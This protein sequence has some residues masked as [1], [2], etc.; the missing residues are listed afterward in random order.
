MNNHW[1]NNNLE[2]VMKQFREMSSVVSP[3]AIEAMKVVEANNSLFRLGAVNEALLKHSQ[4]NSSIAKGAIEAL[5]TAIKGL[6]YS[7]SI[8]AV[9]LLQ[10][11][12]I[13]TIS[14]QMKY[15]NSAISAFSQSSIAELNLTNI[16]NLA[17]SLKAFENLE[18]KEN[19]SEII[20]QSEVESSENSI[21]LPYQFITFNFNLLQKIIEDGKNIFKLT[22]RNFEELIAELFYKE[23]YKV[24]LTKQTRDD[25]KD[26][27]IEKVS[28]FGIVDKYIVECKRY[29]EGNN[30][31][32]EVV[33]R[34]FGVKNHDK[35]N[36]GIVVTTSSFTKK[37]KE[38]ALSHIHEVEL[39]D[40][41]QIIQWMKNVYKV[42]A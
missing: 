20:D 40:Y 28:S 5:T 30:V 6:H 1:K 42:N 24:E 12:S 21:I 18:E 26:L 7:E 16:Q 11:N 25:G 37:A 15:I 22:P 2:R 27:I 41:K 23:G 14:E 33:Q 36:K 3:S 39:K 9:N 19:E 29:K 8:R 38:F 32:I 34:I 31:G 17:M 10:Q 13:F 4:I 35:V